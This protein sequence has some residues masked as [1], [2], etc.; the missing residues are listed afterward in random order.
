MVIRSAIAVGALLFSLA[1]KQGVWEKRGQI[2]AEINDL[3][4][5]GR[6][7][8]KNPAGKPVT[9]ATNHGV[10]PHPHGDAIRQDSAMLEEILSD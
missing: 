6:L 1:E 9:Q 8:A 2:P 4:R 3:G 7:E 10:G 5:S